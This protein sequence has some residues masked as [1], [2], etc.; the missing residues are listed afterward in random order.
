MRS[1][2]KHNAI[3]GEFLWEKLTHARETESGK[4][5]NFLVPEDRLFLVLS[6][7]R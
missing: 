3:V 4:G 7:R 6:Y 1:A 2:G 5:K